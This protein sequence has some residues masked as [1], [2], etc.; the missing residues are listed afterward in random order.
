M[1]FLIS[2]LFAGCQVTVKKP[3]FPSSCDFENGMC[4]WTSAIGGGAKLKWIRTNTSTPASNTGPLWGHPKGSFYIYTN[5][6]N[7]RVSDQGTLLY[8]LKV[9]R[10]SHKG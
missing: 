5:T 4:G 3:V 1:R 9:A 8:F 6:T 10:N 7:A 2:S